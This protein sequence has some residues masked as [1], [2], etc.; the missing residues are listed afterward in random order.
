MKFSLST[1]L[2]TVALLVGAAALE[3]QSPPMGGY[4]NSPYYYG[5]SYG[6]N[7]SN[8]E[9]KFGTQTLL[10]NASGASAS[11]F[12]TFF[13]AVTPANLIPGQSHD[14]I[15][16][17]AGPY[18]CGVCVWIDYDNDGTFNDTN[19]RV[20]FTSTS[21]TGPMTMSFTP[22]LGVGGVRRL[23]LRSNY[24]SAGAQ[25]CYAQYSY[26]EAEDYLVNLGFAI[27]TAN[28][29][30]TAAQGS[31]YSQTITATNG[32]VPYT[33]TLP[34][35]GLPTGMGAAAS[36]NDLVISGTP[37]VP[38]TFQFTLTVTDSKTPTADQAQRQFQ[39][40]VVP[41]PAAMPFID[42]FSTDKGWQLGT[43]WSRGP[44]TAYTPST[45]PPRAEPGTDYSSTTDNNI[46]GDVI[47]G[48]YA[49]N[50]SATQWA[51]SP[52]VNC[53]TG[54]NVKCRIRRW[55]GNAIGT[56]VF[57]QISNNGTA[58]TT[59]WSQSPS[60][61]QSTIRDTSW[62]S[63]TYNISQWASGFATVQMRF[64]VG[65]T[66]STAHTGWCIDDF[67]IYDAPTQLEVREG[68]VAG[69]IITSNQA[70]GGLRDFGSI[71]VGQQS[72]T[73]TIAVINNTTASISFASPFTKSGANPGDFYISAGSFTNPVPVGQ[74][75]TFTVTFY[76]SPSASTG[77]RTA[78]ITLTHNAGG[79]A[80]NQPFVINVRATAVAAAGG[81][82]EARLNNSTGA[83]IAHQS[84]A[85]VANSRDFGDQDPNAGPTP[86]ITIWV[87]NTAAGTLYMTPPDMGG[88]WW[89]E[90]VIDNTG[91]QN[92]LGTGQSTTFKIAFDPTSNGVKD[93][94][95]RLPCTDPAY[96]STGTP[97]Y[98]AIPVKGNGVTP[99]VTPTLLVKEGGAAGQVLPHNAPPIG[100][101]RDFGSQLL[102][103]GPTATLTI[104]IENSG[105]QTLTL[106]TPT[107]TGTGANQF[108]LNT[109]GISLS[110]AAAASTTFTVAFD[111]T[112]TGQKD[113][114]V[115]FTH[116]DSTKTSPFLI[117]VT[118]NGITNAASLTVKAG[119]QTGTTLT[120]G[121]AASGATNF[122]NRDIGAGP[123]AAVQIYIENPGN[124]NLTLGTPT[125]AGAA[126]SQYVLNI[127]GFT[128]TVLPAGNTSFT[129][130]FDPSTTGTKNA[131][132]S[133]THNASS[134][135]TSPFIINLTGNGVPSGPIV[136]VHEQSATGTAVAYNQAVTAGGGR[137]YGSQDIAA[138]A[139]AAKL[140]FIVNSGTQ[141]MTCGLPTMA[142]PDA[143]HFVLS[144]AG[145]TTTIAAGANSSVS[146]TFDPS[147]VGVKDAWLEFTHNDT[148]ATS[149][150]IVNLRGTGTSATGV[151]LTTTTLP[152]GSVGTPYSGATL[153]AAQGTAPYTFSIYSGALP[154]G[155]S[156]TPTGDISGTPT[157]GGSFP[158][159]FRV[160]DATGGTN[161]A[162]IN[163]AVSNAPGLSN[164]RG[165][166]CTS[167]DDASSWL[168]LLGV[169]AALAVGARALK[170]A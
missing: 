83:V 2:V 150:F 23:R 22:A 144:T 51:I 160:T 82:I 6:M 75:T 70:V 163:L 117:N 88:T 165:G 10:S 95:I 21:A 154:G 3:A 166:G 161:D 5:T 19:E 164:P 32:T 134:S 118:G 137:D 89:T 130:A 72:P 55:L 62:Q 115:T 110:L 84:A 153:A 11:P 109:A 74:S 20:C 42:D 56:S 8:V 143:A 159:T 31:A 124:A 170:R 93:A 67:E 48:D 43:T 108:V 152:V 121:A 50:Q 73:L 129:I 101:P 138:G 28:P 29:L 27:A 38:G 131:S 36:G 155:L 37:T 92:T 53:S 47:G 100:T 30:P 102:T 71:P 44:A 158:V 26:G 68:G 16:T 142:G 105:G 86:Y 77:V 17:I 81:V 35:T 33:W 132:I 112:T 96:P 12:N 61:G 46:I 120:N 139:T 99:P 116:N 87:T 18:Q 57:V 9:I 76:V 40:T 64:G 113:A 135:T 78:S 4:N 168:L 49:L 136:E 14:I 103:A 149:P 119:G 15:A 97:G 52:M 128:T 98:F 126:A 125:L 63:I 123:S 148:L 157:S 151:I 167:S 34:V 79:G 39:I 66:G 45:S 65:P 169:L 58:W 145:F 106:G 60:T 127:T 24:Y 69:A 147:S 7:F 41:P 54:T 162:V 1:M 111:P 25:V 140:I 59:V 85:T 94:E 104:Y 146:I 122:G 91:F 107:L 90:F 80:I 13:S 141:S 133:F 156:L 114:Q